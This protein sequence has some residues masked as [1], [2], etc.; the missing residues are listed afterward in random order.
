MKAAEEW[1]KEMEDEDTKGMIPC[2]I[3]D[4]LN[5]FAFNPPSAPYQ[6]AILQPFN[7]E[8]QN[9]ELTY[10]VMVMPKMSAETSCM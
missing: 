9:N 4:S 2:C 6:E 10:V 8:K 7:V 1:N 3:A 5:I